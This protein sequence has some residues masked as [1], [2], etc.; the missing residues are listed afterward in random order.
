MGVSWFRQVH[1]WYE[2]QVEWLRKNQFKLNAKTKLA[3]LFGG[4][5]A[6]A[7]AA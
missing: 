6:V 5:Q 7:F 4:N 2:W 1:V 3:N